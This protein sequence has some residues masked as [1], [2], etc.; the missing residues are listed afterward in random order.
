M[1][2]QL[3]NA[4]QYFKEIGPPDIGDSMSQLTQ[5][6]IG[7]HERK[8]ARERQARLDA[9]AAEEQASQMQNAEEARQLRLL[10]IQ[11]KIEALKPRKTEAVPFEERA[12]AG[13][14]AAMIPDTPEERAVFEQQPI[15]APTAPQTQ[16]IT[17]A[18]QTI[19]VPLQS[20]TDIEEQQAR[21]FITKLGQER[22]LTEARQKAYQFPTGEQFGAMSGLEIPEGAVGSAL[23]KLMTPQKAIERT[24]DLGDKVEY[25]YA[26]GTREVKPKGKLPGAGQEGPTP[27]SLLNAQ[28]DIGKSFQRYTTDAKTAKTQHSI[29]K[30]SL[31]EAQTAI[32][33][34]R[35]IGPSSQA[36]ITA[37]GRIIDPGSTVRESEYARTPEG[38]S[39]LHRIEGFT[40]RM[41]Q[42][43]AG[44][45]PADL[46][47]VS[48][49][50]DAFMKGYV[51]SQLNY[52]KLAKKQAEMIGKLSKGQLGDLETVLPPDMLQLLQESESGGPAAGGATVSPTRARNPQTGEIIELVNGQWQP[53]RQ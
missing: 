50:A 2:S 10:D 31:T 42:G 29:L 9:M 21:D 18:G 33:E 8:L 11:Q 35:G 26:D 47:D 28:M 14:V 17:I 13:D 6:L 36:L 27:T 45:T 53:V 1:A 15:Q 51:N 12:K 44:L 39:L 41:R 34:G 30:A 52:A 3:R 43:G 19:E 46:T 5:S 38:L 32:K 48:K 49:A 40:I 22:Q 23:S 37:F 25:I 20:R 7:I 16:K 24:V 4:A